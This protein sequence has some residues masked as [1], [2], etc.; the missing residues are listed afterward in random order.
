M[1]FIEMII[2]HYKSPYQFWVWINFV[3]KV[4]FF[5]FVNF[6]VTKAVTAKI[7]KKSE[8]SVIYNNIDRH[9]LH[10]VVYLKGVNI[11]GT[12]SEGTG[13]GPYSWAHLRF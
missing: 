3:F 2:N 9:R 5:F 10:D 11:N 4:L 8:F 6:Y 7:E 12:I 13:V 1:A